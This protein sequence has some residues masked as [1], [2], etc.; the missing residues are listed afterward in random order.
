MS[1]AKTKRTIENLRQK[2]VTSRGPS[3]GPQVRSERELRAIADRVLRLAKSRRIPETEV[4]VEEIVSA[5]TRFAGNAI[6]QHVAEQGITVSV[7]TVADG[8]TAR[9]T[10]KW[11]VGEVDG[12]T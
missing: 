7:R 11:G 4:H 6:H 5:L 10:T 3:A 12:G 1:P 8:R 2:N 9:V